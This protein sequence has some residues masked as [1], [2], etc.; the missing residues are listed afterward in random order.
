VNARDAMPNG[1]TIGLRMQNVTFEDAGETGLKGDFV[2]ISISDT[3]T[4]IAPEHLSRVFEP[5][6]TTKGAG[7][8]S[9]LGLSQ[10]YGF[11]RHSGGT[12]QVRSEPGRGAAFTIF[13]P[14]SHEAA[15]QAATAAE[16]PEPQE[17]PRGTVL[18]VED[19]SR[20]AEVSAALVQ[21]I[22]YRTI[23]AASAREALDLLGSEKDIVLVFSDIVMPGNMDGIQLARSVRERHPNVPVLSTSG[24]A[25]MAEAAAGQFPI[26]RK[27]YELSAL[28]RA[29]RSAIQ[30]SAASA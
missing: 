15:A 23:A 21:Q 13:L 1:G 4:G 7:K 3:G 25:R 26:L 20:V 10:V 8:G 9:G 5:F 30:S 14:R 29:V 11:A 28:A 16:T 22:G 2:A 12:V 19:N 24:Y 6:F 17:P 18:I 27:P